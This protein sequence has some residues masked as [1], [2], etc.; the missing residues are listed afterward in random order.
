M[1]WAR[2]VPGTATPVPWFP[3]HTTVGRVKYT[4]LQPGASLLTSLK[5]DGWGAYVSGTGTAAT[6]SGEAT[7]AVSSGAGVKPHV[8]VVR[9][10][11]AL[12]NP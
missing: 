2:F 1:A 6:A 7:L 9:F 10:K 8:A 3:L 4:A 5:S 12:T 11:G